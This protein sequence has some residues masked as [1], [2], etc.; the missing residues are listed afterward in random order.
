MIITNRKAKLNTQLIFIS[1]YQKL[2]EF[3]LKANNQRG[4]KYKLI[5]DYDLSLKLTHDYLCLHL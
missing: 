3:I 5:P 4:K 1:Q 2:I